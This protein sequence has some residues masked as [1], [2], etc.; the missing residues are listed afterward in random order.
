M[1]KAAAEGMTAMLD[2]WRQGL[3]KV[4]EELGDLMS[5]SDCLC[6]HDTIG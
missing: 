5:L 3:G 6:L 2:L 4:P 1:T